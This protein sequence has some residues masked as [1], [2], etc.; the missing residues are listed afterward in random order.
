MNGISVDVWRILLVVALAVGLGLG[1]VLTWLRTP[2][3][4][5]LDDTWRDGYEEGCNDEAASFAALPAV[6][7][8]DLVL[9][10]ACEAAGL[11]EGPPAVPAGVG[12]EAPAR[13][14]MSW[15]ETMHEQLAPEHIAG[16]GPGEHHNPHCEDPACNPEL[17]QRTEAERQFAFDWDVTMWQLEM[18]ADIARVDRE[19]AVTA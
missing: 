1:S 7:A 15:L 5:D 18:A 10:D 6:P 17:P 8:E 9:P 12:R 16:P 4:A 14:D 2:S 13:D 19:L 3:R 11:A